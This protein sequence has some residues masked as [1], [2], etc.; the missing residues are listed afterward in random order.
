MKRILP[1]DVGCGTEDMH[2]RSTLETGQEIAIVTIHLGVSPAHHSFK[3]EEGEYRNMMRASNWC[4]SI[5][6]ARLNVERFGEA[7]AEIV[8][9]GENPL[10]ALAAE[11]KARLPDL[12]R[13]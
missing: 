2:I 1:D 13:P 7:L 12:F 5:P 9:L 11:L 10:D 3:P 6:I 4:R 8:P